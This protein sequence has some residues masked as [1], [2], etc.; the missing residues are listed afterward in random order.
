MCSSYQ[1][2]YHGKADGKKKCLG[3]KEEAKNKRFVEKVEIYN[4]FKRRHITFSGVRD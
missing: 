1:R 3:K 2:V 4:T